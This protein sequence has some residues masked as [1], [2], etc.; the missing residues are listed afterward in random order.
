[1]PTFC[2][3]MAAWTTIG[4]SQDLFARQFTYAGASRTSSRW[5]TGPA[6]TAGWTIDQYTRDAATGWVLSSSDS[7]GQTTGYQY[8]SLHRI[9]K[10]TPP[11]EAPTSVCYSDART[12][13]VARGTV[14]MNCPITRSASGVLTWQQLDFDALGRLVR[15]TRRMPGATYAKRFTLYDPRDTAYFSSQ[16]VPE[17][18]AEGG[19]SAV[20]TSCGDE[21]PSYASSRPLN[22]P[23]AYRLCFDPLGRPQQ[24]VGA[25]HSSLV[26]VDR[27]D[28][29]V[30]FSDTRETATVQCL[31]ASFVTKASDP[32]AGSCNA[33]G[34][35]AVTRTDRD[36]F[37][38]IIGVTEAGGDFTS[39][40]YDVNGKLTCV[41]Q[42]GT[43]HGA[44]ACLSNPGG[45]AREFVHD[46][47]GFLRSETTPEK[48]FVSFGDYGSLGNLLQQSEPGGVQTFRLYDFAGRQLCEGLGPT[49]VSGVCED[50]G[51]SLFSRSFYDGN[52][53]AGG[54]WSK[55]KLT[56]RIGFN[57][58]TF[59]SAAVTED[60]TY[61]SPAGGRLSGKSTQIANAPASGVAESWSY[62]N[63]GLVGTHNHPRKS[64][65]FAVSAVYDAGL[66]ISVSAGG[67]SVL[68]GVTYQPSGAVATY[69]A[70]NGVRTTIDQDPSSLPRPARIYTT[71]AGYDSGTYGYDGA[72]N[73]IKIGSDSFVYDP[74]S[75]LTSATLAGAEFGTQSFSYDPYGNLTSKTTNGVATSYVLDAANHVSRS[76]GVPVA[77]DP[78]GNIATVGSE[79]FNHDGLNRLTRH[80]AGGSDW[81]YVYNAVDER[82]AK[83]PGSDL[84]LR[85]QMAVLLVQA[86]GESPSSGCKAPTRFTD[87]PCAD[88][89][90]GYIEKL[91]ADGI[92]GGCGAGQFCPGLTVPRDEMATFLSKGKYCPLNTAC[93]AG[94][95]P[96]A[97][98][99][100]WSDVPAGNLHLSNINRIYADQVTSGCATSPPAY[101]PTVKVTRWQMMVFL[102]RYWPAYDP[103]LAANSIFTFRDESNR[104]S[105]EFLDGAVQRDNVYLGNLLVASKT[106]LGWEYYSSDHLGTPRRVT[107]SATMILKYWP[108][109]DEPGTPLPAQ[110]LQFSTME[111]DVE[112][113]RYYDHARSADFSLGRFL[114]PDR[115][116]GHVANP[117][118]WNRY[119]YCLGN[120]LKHVD[121]DGQLTILVHGTWAAGS[122]DFRPGGKF[123]DYV[124]LTHPGQGDRFAPVVWS[125]FE[126]RHGRRPL[127][128]WPATFRFTS[129]APAEKLTIV[130]AQP[131]RQCR[132]R[133]DQCRPREEGRQSR[134]ARDAG[135]G[136]TTR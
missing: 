62:T 38:R 3:P 70:G 136:M 81:S 101:C 112:G 125:G 107:G 27:V 32:N 52:G 90:W 113:K 72:G 98:N 91:A 95:V 126:S 106:P 109:G 119:A 29:A 123:F 49:P 23:G 36:A 47:A 99:P 120:P 68:T 118:S 24:I 85:R 94:S 97:P 9:T 54:A 7:A 69:T 55:G 22:A 26:T 71:P 115:I 73:V 8:D 58:K 20:A 92:T 128:N 56:R 88:P 25:G 42:R 19:W 82:V 40:R 21:G 30:A 93:P 89:D 14:A 122:S 129:S 78:R 108:Y 130:C 77:P 74:R 86:R 16:W 67:Q 18:S 76:G 102:A 131:R 127:E 121:P 103:P 2:G 50:A 46:A 110:R 37:G 45:Q 60:F 75:R 6:A 48:G 100:G 135:P 12:T 13:V 15:E 87:V 17:S 5:M 34:V 84:V 124:R 63:L 10:V 4:K 39:Y 61:D 44:T 104:V 1:M 35:S 33:G 65:A 132:D 133:S 80:Q 64:G 59:P 96:S 116:G 43:G 117:Q 57:P 79:A 28:G 134:H 41:K 51:S 105:T 11:G 83:I 114:S 66:P 111:R 31:N 53:S